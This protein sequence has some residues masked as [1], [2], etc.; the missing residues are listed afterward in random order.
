MGRIQALP[1]LPAPEPAG[2]LEPGQVNHLAGLDFPGMFS[3][4][5]NATNEVNAA[6]ARV[7][8]S[9]VPLSFLT[10]FSAISGRETGDAILCW[11][12]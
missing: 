9:E 10:E 2:F 7:K 8:A 1:P 5:I 12:A 11:P 3:A 6:V 4:A